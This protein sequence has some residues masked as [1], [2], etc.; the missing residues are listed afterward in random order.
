ARVRKG[1]L[2]ASGA[3]ASLLGAW[4]TLRQPS[5]EREWLL[6]EPRGA[7]TLITRGGQAAEPLSEAL[8][9]VSEGELEVSERA[10]LTTPSGIDVQL[11]ERTRVGLDAL[12]ARDGNAELRLV[13]GRVDCSVPPLGQS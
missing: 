7:A 8:R 11:G 5:P 1:V 12:V 3:L 6:L 4:F 9:V 10:A 2:A 13:S